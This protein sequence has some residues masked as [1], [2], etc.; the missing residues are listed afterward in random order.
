MIFS[1]LLVLAITL[2][3]SS[4]ASGPACVSPDQAGAVRATDVMN[5][6]DEII[7]RSRALSTG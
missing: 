3:R 7:Q 4:P 5:S 2:R 6:I 1:S